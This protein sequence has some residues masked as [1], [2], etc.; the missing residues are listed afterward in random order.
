MIKFLKGLLTDEDA[1]YVFFAL[2]WFL[3]LL[4]IIAGMSY[5]FVLPF[6]WLKIVWVVIGIALLFAVM[7]IGCIAA[8]RML[9]D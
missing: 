7:F 6:L 8:I 3:A 9:R 4:A 1:K 5:S 2:L